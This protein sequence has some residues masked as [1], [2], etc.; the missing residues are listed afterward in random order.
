LTTGHLIQLWDS[1]VTTKAASGGNIS[2]HAPLFVLD[3][4]NITTST[5]LSGEGDIFIQAGRLIRTPDSV[6]RV[7][8]T[9]TITAPNTEV[10]GSLIVLPETL[11]D[12]SGQLREAC[13]GDSR[14]APPAGPVR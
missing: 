10:A 11:F 4:G 8:G 5:Q 9:I 14:L 6:V 3:H 1:T 2:M 7:S 12:L 13:A